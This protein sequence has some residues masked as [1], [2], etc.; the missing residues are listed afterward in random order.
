MKEKIIYTIIIL[1][2]AQTIYLVINN[3]QLKWENGRLKFMLYTPAEGIHQK[4]K[5][6]ILPA[7]FG[8]NI[9]DN[10]IYLWT[11]RQDANKKFHVDVYD[12]SYKYICTTSHYNFWEP[13]QRS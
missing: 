10:R 2:C 12:R 11:S 9:D 7:L 4:Q 6:S 8:I 3:R 13:T 1:L 5:S